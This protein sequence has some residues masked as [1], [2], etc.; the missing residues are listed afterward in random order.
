MG[1]AESGNQDHRHP[2]SRGETLE[3]GS[4][5]RFY[6]DFRM[7]WGRTEAGSLA[8][9]PAPGKALSDPIGVAVWVL[10]NP[11]PIPMFPGVCECLGGCFSTH[12]ESVS[13]DE[14][15]ANRPFCTGKELLET[16]R[17]YLPLL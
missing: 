9:D 3:G 12:L 16:L 13:G 5:F 7:I 14:G 10:H 1:P 17:F 4:E 2:L 6:N 8:A 15:I 11:D